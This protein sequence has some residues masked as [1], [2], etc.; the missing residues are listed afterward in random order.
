MSPPHNCRLFYFRL[1]HLRG[2]IYILLPNH[3][4]SNSQ[5]KEKIFLKGIVISSEIGCFT[6]QVPLRFIASIYFILFFYVKPYLAVIEEALFFVGRGLWL[7]TIEIVGGCGNTAE[8]NPK[9][10]RFSSRR[11][12]F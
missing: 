6:T 4:D 11:V 2:G 5:L 3:V 1:F 10:L 12:L 8:N 7:L 9:A